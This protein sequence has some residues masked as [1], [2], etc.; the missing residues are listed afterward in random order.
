MTGTLRVPGDKSIAHRALI[1]GSIARGKQVV[2]GVP[3]STDLQS[4]MSCLRSLGTFLEEMP[5]GRILVLA[6]EFASGVT[7]DAG[8]SGT[9]ARLLSGL[10]AAHPIETAIDGDQ[11]LRRRPMDRIAEPLSRMG[12]TIT[13]SEGRLPMRI[14]GGDLKGI[15]YRLPVPSAQVKSA[16]LIAGLGADG[17]TV[18]EEGIPTRDHTERLLRAMAVPV[19]D[20]NGRIS[21]QG[22]AVPKATHVKI[23]GDISSAA[24][25]I[26]AAL[27]LDQ[28]EIYLPTL[29][30]NP[31][32][33]GLI[34]VLEEMGANIEYVNR[35]M[36]LE[37]PI[38]DIAVRSSGLTG[39]TVAD[40]LI[41]SL[42]DELPIL[43]VAATQAEG[44]T[45]VS[46]AQELRHKES[47]RIASTVDSLKTLGADIE[48]RADGFVV[49]GPTRLKGGT[50]SSFGDHRIAMA[51]AMAG[52]LADGETEIEGSDV[53]DVSYPAFF[54]DVIAV[55]RLSG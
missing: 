49:R 1:L 28:S 12:A 30:V 15:T 39:V 37:E 52:L 29:G 22:S 47:D 31:T 42:I 32:R 17:D 18:V 21:V 35:D 44:E 16:I 27:C 34:R 36:F 6:K 48:A 11:S 10:L 51:M 38:A 23:P 9:T 25:F 7:L 45:V 41:P 14:K 8:N 13:T 19:E 55:V 40:E 4:T 20:E 54:N 33:T 5:D 46:G 43:A 2:E 24:F 26:V 50:V 3:L 53:I